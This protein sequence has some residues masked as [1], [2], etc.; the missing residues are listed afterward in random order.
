[1]LCT[2]FIRLFFSLNPFFRAIFLLSQH[3]FHSEFC[4]ILYAYL[5]SFREVVLKFHYSFFLILDFERFLNNWKLVHR[6]I[7]PLVVQTKP[8]TC[9][10]NFLINPQQLCSSTYIQ[11]FVCFFAFRDSRC[12]FGS[13][14]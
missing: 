10:T 13:K 9:N 8:Q 6:N 5:F 7:C 2:V 1:M 11:P 12:F 3:N 4:R 14:S